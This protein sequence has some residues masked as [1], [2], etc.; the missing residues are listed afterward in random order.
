MEGERDEADRSHPNENE[1]GVEGEFVG[2]VRGDPDDDAQRCEHQHRA[3][4]ARY[5]P[6]HRG[7]PFPLKP[8]NHAVGERVEPVL[9][10]AVSDLEG[11]WAEE[12]ADDQRDGHE[13]EPCDDGDRK[14]FTPHRV[15][16]AMHRYQ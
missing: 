9:G 15:A 14:S 1:T 7:R 3:R 13:N 11:V 8:E 6:C 4:G 10:A 5:S 12:R 2:R 16:P